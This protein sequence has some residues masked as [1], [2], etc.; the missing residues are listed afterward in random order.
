MV[1]DSIDHAIR[2]R[3]QTKDRSNQSIHWTHQYAIKGSVINPLLDNSKAEKRLD[4]LQ[5]MDL[6]PT[7][8][9]Q[10]RLKKT[11]AIIVSRAVTTHLNEFQSLRSVVIK[12]IPHPFSAEASK[13]SEM[14]STWPQY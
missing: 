8:E 14:V 1:G 2:A 10:A 9:V 11:W 12:H 6:L 4:Q 13:K 7:P 3:V 5:L